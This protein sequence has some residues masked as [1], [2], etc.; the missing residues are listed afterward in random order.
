MKKSILSAM[1]LTALTS[2]SAFAAHTFTN[3]AGDSLTLDGRFDVLYHDKGEV[4][5]SDTNSW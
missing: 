1:I 2:G 5:N 4:F 3:D